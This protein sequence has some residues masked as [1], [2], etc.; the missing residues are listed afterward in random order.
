MGAC[1]RGLPNFF[2]AAQRAAHRFMIDRRTF[3][4]TAAAVPVAAH[5]G[6]SELLGGSASRVA[7]I[8][9]G[10]F[11][12]WTAWHLQKLGARVELIDAWGP[13][14]VRSSSGGETRVIRAV[15]GTDRIYVE[16]V[17]RSF[18]L[19]EQLAAATD[20]PVYIET[21]ALWLHRGDDGY[22]RSSLASL[23]D[24]GFV[25]EQLPVDE[26][27]R[28]YPQIS[29]AGIQSV[30]LEK[31][32]GALSARRACAIVRDRFVRN[33][34]AYRTAHATPGRF[35]NGRLRE[36]KLGDGSRLQA[37][38][39]VFACGPWLG[40]LFPDV[41][42]NAIRPTKQEVFYFGTP[43]G[44]TRYLPKNFPIWIDFGERI[45]YGLPDTH[46]RGVKIAD[47]TRGDLF[48]PTD[49]E[50][51]PGSDAIARARKVIAERFPE[52][53]KAPLLHAEVCQYENSPDGHLV[54]D[55]H[56]GAANVWLAGGG[57]GHGFKLAPAV[58]EMTASAIVGT[59]ALPKLFSI[60]RLAGEVR[61]KTQFQ[62]DGT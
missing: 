8:G 58:G 7:V 56:P 31:R 40:K 23:N 39:F 21:G 51:K 9:A 2:R 38:A 27:A 30:W 53:A 47:D 29:F 11:G 42:G 3:M 20:E 32:A 19:W 48:D 43:T 46:A 61:P 22:V 57:S 34:G 28:R 14:N 45:F 24:L 15:Y 55:R 25:V 52:L 62:S 50:R 4:K 5:F 33:G 49:G 1:P 54:I 12:S 10:A 26:A 37:D 6:A 18:A 17:K 59:K 60:E 35:T 16:M 13:G 44:S 36:L 41:I